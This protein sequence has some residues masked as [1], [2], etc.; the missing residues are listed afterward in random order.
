MRGVFLW[1][2]NAHVVG[3]PVDLVRVRLTE[4][5]CVVTAFFIL[6][7][8]GPVLE[9]ELYEFIVDLEALLDSGV[10][11][12]RKGLVSDLDRG[13]S[14]WTLYPDVRSTAVKVMR[15]K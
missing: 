12:M 6:R 1:E 5:I 7:K 4:L 15:V 14:L 9:D 8:D 2:P 10:I 13:L 3:Q 11:Q